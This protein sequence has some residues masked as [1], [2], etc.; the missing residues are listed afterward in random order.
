M[1]FVLA[2]IDSVAALGVCVGGRSPRPGCQRRPQVLAGV[3]PTAQVYRRPGAQAQRGVPD[4]APGRSRTGNRG[5]GRLRLADDAPAATLP[6]CDWGLGYEEGIEL[7]LPHAQA[8]RTLATLA[9]LRARIRFEDGHDADAID[10]IVDAMTLGRHVSMDGSLITVLLDYGIE[11]RAGETLA[12]YLPKLD[13]EMIKGLKTRLAAL[14]PAG[15]P[16]GGWCR[17][18]RKPAWTG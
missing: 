13:P 3:R 8:A 15:T 2:M 6:R 18:R 1:R 5:Q 4:H 14:P 16:A 10:D 17:S 12:L 11:Y 7:L 9:C